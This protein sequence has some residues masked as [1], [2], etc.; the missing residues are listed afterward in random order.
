MRK[1]MFAVCLLTVLLLSSCKQ[2]LAFEFNRYTRVYLPGITAN[3]DMDAFGL[4]RDNG[5]QVFQAGD[6]Y[7]SS[8]RPSQPTAEDNVR[9]LPM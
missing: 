6:R 1:P 2:Y 5:N 8:I 7:I 3:S 9:L 4:Y